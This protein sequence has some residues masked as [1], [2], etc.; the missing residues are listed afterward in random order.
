MI[1]HFKEKIRNVAIGIFGASFFIFWVLG[2]WFSYLSFRIGYR[3]T[4]ID[5][6]ALFLPLLFSAFLLFY[7]LW[8]GEESSSIRRKFLATYGLLAAAIIWLVGP[9]Q[10]FFVLNLDYTQ[11]SLSAFSY[12][13]EGLFFGIVVVGLVLRRLKKVDEFLADYHSKIKSISKSRVEEVSEIISTYP[14]KVSAL[15]FFAVL[16][17]YF[18]GAAILF[19]VGG[20]SYRDAIKDALT[21]LAIAP[22]LFLSVYVITYK[23]LRGVNEILYTF[24]D[25]L[26]PRRVLFIGQKMMLLGGAFLLLMMMMFLPLFWDCLSETISDNKL[27]GGLA[28]MS[29]EFA[30]IIY[31]STRAF[32]A[33][34]QSALVK[35]E[36]GLEILQSENWDYRLNIKTGDELENI[37]YDY[38]KAVEELRKGR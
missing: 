32:I 6:A 38:N 7:L 14:L 26:R 12:L 34:L 4:W 15:G 17:G 28:V 23:Y 21:G 29:V 37:A 1:N 27:I 25:V 10:S 35:I 13:I 36:K 9:I 19:W 2:I 3:F 33:D 16:G 22:I 5:F 8:P 20:V 11:I 30:L 18:L 24:G 31:L